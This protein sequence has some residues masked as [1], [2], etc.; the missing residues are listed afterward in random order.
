MYLLRFDA[1]YRSC[2]YLCCRWWCSFVCVEREIKNVLIL[3]ITTSLFVATVET[4]VNC[5]W[6]YGINALFYVQMKKY[7][8]LTALRTNTKQLRLFWKRRWNKKRKEKWSNKFCKILFWSENLKKCLRISGL[9][10]C[11]FEIQKIFGFQH[12]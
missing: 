12:I 9:Y 5:G 7:P 3:P 11:F 4:M 6:N 10:I 1:S 8:N 2:C